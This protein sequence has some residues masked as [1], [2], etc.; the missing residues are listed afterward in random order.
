MTMTSRI[1]LPDS[2]VAS[3]ADHLRTI[4][5]QGEIAASKIFTKPPHARDLESRIL[6]IS[7]SVG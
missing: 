3:A 4:G 5:P 7:G 2:F 6:L 1:V